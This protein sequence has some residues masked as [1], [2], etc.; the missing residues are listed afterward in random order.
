MNKKFF[1]KEH[2]WKNDPQNFSGTIPL[3]LIALKFY[4]QIL[5]LVKLTAYVHFLIFSHK[6]SYE[7]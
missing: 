6:D 5:F 2:L 1:I 4:F 3:L 7:I